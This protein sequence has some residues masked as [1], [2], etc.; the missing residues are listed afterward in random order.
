[1]NDYYADGGNEWPTLVPIRRFHIEKKD[2]PENLQSDSGELVELEL[3]DTSG[4][5]LAVVGIEGLDPAAKYNAQ[6]SWNLTYDRD[7]EAAIS[8]ET[9][10]S[11]LRALSD[12]KHHL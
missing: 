6:M 1:M 9:A 4:K 11:V 8:K 7:K 3:K 12:M 10:R 5:V 2:V